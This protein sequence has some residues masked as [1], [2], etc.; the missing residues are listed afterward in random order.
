MG[1]GCGATGRFI[2]TVNGPKCKY[3]YGEGNDED[4]EKECSHPPMT[5]PETGEIMD[6]CVFHAP[7]VDK[8]ERVSEFWEAFDRHFESTVW[9]FKAAGAKE[10]D[11]VQLDCE[12]FVFPET[13]EKLKRRFRFNVDFT[14]AKFEGIANFIGGEFEGKVDFFGAAF[15]GD[16]CF[17]GTLFPQESSFWEVTFVGEA[18]FAWAIFEGKADFRKATFVKEVSFWATTF[19]DKVDFFRVTFGG[20]ANFWGTTF[21]GGAHFLWATFAQAATFKEAALCDTRFY[22]VQI[23]GF[24]FSNAILGEF[25]QTAEYD[26]GKI[27]RLRPVSSADYTGALYNAHNIYFN[28][29]PLSRDFGKG[30]VYY[31]L[32][33]GLR[34][35]VN[36]MLINVFKKDNYL[37]E[38]NPPPKIARF[39]RTKFY[40]VDT[41]AVDWSKNPRLGRDI[42]YQQF[43]GQFWDRGPGYRF[44]YFLWWLTSRC[45]ESFKRWLGWSAAIVLIFA[46]LYA[47]VW[48]EGGKPLIAEG[49][50]NS[51]ANAPAMER[52]PFIT[53]LYFSVATFT[54]LGFGDVTQVSDWGK[55]VVGLEVIIGYIM[56]GGLIALF[57]NKLVR[58]E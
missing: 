52:P 18:F 23:K 4:N 54:T 9:E 51:A 2:V 49:V 1:V 15:K 12:G 19:E 33:F 5:D 53:A 46:G 24:D 38:F 28:V 32:A 27:H 44:L 16:A 10:K 14:Q 39:Q 42:R 55:F 35:V 56:L 25:A 6:Y 13:G 3:D 21:K 22:D 50:I 34:W 48:G 37:P 30:L 40:G 7:M 45:G 57:A 17:S 31:S 8:A 11:G 36:W 43:L 29:N 20:K 41:S 47:Y 58:R 26:G